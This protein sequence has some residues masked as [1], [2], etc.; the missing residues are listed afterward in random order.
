MGVPDPKESTVLSRLIVASQQIGCLLGKGG[1][2][3]TEIRKLSGAQVRILGK[4]Q[5][6]KGVP[7]NYGMVQV[8]FDCLRFCILATSTFCSLCICIKLFD[9]K[10]FLF[11][12]LHVYC[13]WVI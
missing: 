6:P 7:E 13:L 2:V 9:L 4:E 12:L 3:I 10:V 5:I 8:C 11:F 1:A